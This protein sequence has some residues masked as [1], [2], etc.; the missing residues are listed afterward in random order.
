MCVGMSL[1]K[2][3]G[4]CIKS[5]GKDVAYKIG[6]EGSNC[7]QEMPNSIFISVCIY[8]RHERCAR[9]LIIV[10]YN[11]TSLLKSKQ[12]TRFTAHRKVDTD[13]ERNPELNITI[14]KHTLPPLG[15]ITTKT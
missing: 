15:K 3:T 12:Q 6:Q 9:K 11:K 1:I 2:A 10:L 8:L 13:R 14:Q 4:I 5:Q 7:L